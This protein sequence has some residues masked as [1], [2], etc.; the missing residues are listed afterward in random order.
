MH[1]QPVCHGHIGR[2]ELHA[3]LQD[4]STGMDVAEGYLAA[5]RIVGQSS[6]CG[7]P[8]W[9]R[10]AGDLIRGRGVWLKQPMDMGGL[11]QPIILSRPV[12]AFL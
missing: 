3:T 10:R 5:S 2:D 6:R 12:V 11:V 9:V 4:R 1:R 8:Q 7:R